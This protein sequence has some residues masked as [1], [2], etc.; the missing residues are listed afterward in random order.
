MSPN[1]KTTQN[2]TTVPPHISVNNGR[3][4]MFQVPIL[5]ACTVGRHM[6]HMNKRCVHLGG[7]GAWWCIGNHGW[8]VF[9]AIYCPFMLISNILQLYLVHSMYDRFLWTRATKEGKNVKPTVIPS[10]SH[11]IAVFILF[12]RETPKAWRPLCWTNQPNNN[13]RPTTNNQWP[14]DCRGIKIQLQ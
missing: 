9:V 12:W 4:G 7:G 8:I 11:G 14:T 3:M 13:K 6:S 10:K 1:L 5:C 2:P